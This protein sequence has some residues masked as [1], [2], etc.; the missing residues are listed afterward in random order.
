MSTRTT[1]HTQE[2]RDELFLVKS[3]FN[4]R[5]MHFTV[6]FYKHGNGFETLKKAI[7]AVSE[8]NEFNAA[9]VIKAFESVE[10]LVYSVQFGR[11]YSPVMYIKAINPDDG[12][13]IIQKFGAVSLADEIGVQDDKLT[14]RFWWD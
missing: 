4:G 13:E 10:D 6:G 1:T 2:V 9:R 7:R 12:T 11:E 14:L 5:C 8:Y 3:G